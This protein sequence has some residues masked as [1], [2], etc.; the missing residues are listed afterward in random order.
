[1][2]TAG[3]G[4]A[5]LGY[6]AAVALLAGLA[7]GFSGF[8]AALIFVPLASRVVGPQLA[9]PVLMLIDTC[10][11]LGLLPSAWRLA[12]RR[13]VGLLTAG[14][15]LGVPLGTWTLAMAAPRALRWALVLL[16]GLL[17][18][19]LLS[20]W[21]YCGRPAPPVAIAT[22]SL[23]GY[24]SGL[25]QMGGPPVVAFWL[26]GPGAPAVIRANIILY[27]GLAGLISALSYLLGGLVSGP[28]LQLALVSGPFYGAGL[29]LGTR[30][31]RQAGEVWFR[32]ICYGLIALAAL[33]SLPA[34]D[35]LL[36][37]GG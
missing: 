14:A 36:P 22:G 18:A 28:V 25:A 5:A 33:L 3:F 19:L 26:G 32:R 17:L 23:A 13:A 12:D 11:T 16:V 34:L 35:G 15:L 7:R 24:L 30:G 4:S 2:S 37:G 1:M 31:F 8:G 9:A 20:G 6:V 29:V 21:R 10:L 27:F